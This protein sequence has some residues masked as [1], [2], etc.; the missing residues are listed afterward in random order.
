MGEMRSEHKILVGKPEGKTQTQIGRWDLKE[1]GY[2][3][4]DWDNLSPGQ[5]LGSCGNVN[6]SRNS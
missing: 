5:G 4:V 1:T 2:E 6:E 3:G